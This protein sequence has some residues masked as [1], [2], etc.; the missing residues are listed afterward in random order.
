MRDITWNPLIISIASTLGLGLLFSY[1]KR[2]ILS[3]LGFSLFIN[4]YSLQ[5]YP[6]INA[7]FTHMRLYNGE[8][9]YEWPENPFF[10]NQSVYSPQNALYLIYRSDNFNTIEGCFR[11]AMAINVAI[12][13]V[14]GRVGMFEIFITLILGTFGSELNRRVCKN[15]GDDAFGSMYIFAFGGFLGLAMGIILRLRDKANATLRN[16]LL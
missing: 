5:Y 15:F 1:N 12:S 9:G 7:L 6:L 11:S 10:L 8:I 2:L 4:A 3:G 13:C 14:M 16:P